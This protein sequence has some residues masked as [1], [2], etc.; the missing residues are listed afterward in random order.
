MRDE[1]ADTDGFNFTLLS[2]FENAKRTVTN[3]AM[4]LL[5]FEWYDGCFIKELIG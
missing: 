4:C 1:S 3:R 5:G 2:G